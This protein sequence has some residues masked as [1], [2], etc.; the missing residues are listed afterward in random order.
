MNNK[1][2]FFVID[3]ID[4]SGKGTQT[5]MIIQRL[6]D[7]NFPL[8]VYDFPQY[9]KRSCTM[10]EDLLNGKFGAIENVSPYQASIFYAIDR[11]EAS[12]NMKKDLLDGKIIISNRYVSS[13]QIH[14]SGK[15]D[16]Q[17]ELDKFLVWLEELEYGIFKIPKPDKVIFLNMPWQIAMELTKNKEARNYIQ[18]IKKIDKAE[19]S[20]EHQRRSYN[21]ACSL[22]KRFDNW[23]EILC[24]NEKNEIKSPEEI[25][26]EIYQILKTEILGYKTPK[27]L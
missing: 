8:A 25:N 19:E 11:Y 27:L 24:I 3:G 16:D 26:E 10:V 12:F 20:E 17:N 9:G 5:K 2:K 18:G 13:N 23:K 1:G 21:R 7:E 4:G 22:V 6:I 14:Q 15:I